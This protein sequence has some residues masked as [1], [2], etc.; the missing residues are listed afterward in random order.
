MTALTLTLLFLFVGTALAASRPAHMKLWLC[1][2]AHERSAWNDPDPPYFGGL[3]M[4]EWFHRTYAG[5][6][7]RRRGHADRWTPME[8]MWVAENA[9]RRERYSRAWVFH[10][11][12]TARGCL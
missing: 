2:H 8:Q 3:Q 11:W 9:Y 10:Q 6:L 12:P 1:I 4:G 7:T 5:D